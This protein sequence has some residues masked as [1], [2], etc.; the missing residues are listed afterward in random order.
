MT[1][2]QAAVLGIVQGLTE[3]V[4]ISS[5][6]HLVLVPTLLGWQRPPVAFDV[7]LHT[8]TLIGVLIYFAPDILQLLR[9]SIRQGPERRMIT[10]LA[11]GTV[12]AAVVGVAF[13]AQVS[14]VFDEPRLTAGLLIGT[15]VVL[16]FS[17]LLA[18]RRQKEDV[19]PDIKTL[20][21]A[22]SPT[23]ALAV[24]V[25]Q[26]ISILPGFSRSG[27]TIAIG[28][29]TGLTRVQAARF[30][31]LLSIPILAGTSVYE[32]PD[33]AEL[34]VSTGEL[35][36]GF[37]AALMSGFAAV[38]FMIGYLQRRGL[39]PFAIYCFVVGIVLVLVLPS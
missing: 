2:F 12:P 15:A 26:A 6:A 1:V 17:E 34:G 5:S 19:E 7:L 3:F 21:D 18:R 29:G 27:W 28:L 10:Y 24:G 14:E 22:V 36:A 30:S 38:A 8:G 20:S 33:I 32:I 23:K 39:Y 11:I 9:G 37:F 35:A 16:L 4:P 13:G 31:F 25:G